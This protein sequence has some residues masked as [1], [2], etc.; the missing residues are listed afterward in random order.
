MP[1]IDL[2]TG[3]GLDIIDTQ[4]G[5]KTI[6]LLHG[7]ADTAQHMTR[8][9]DWL[10]PH[11]R[12]IAPTL[13]GY[14]ESTPKPRLF[15]VDF[16]DV[17]ARDV[18]ALMDKLD[19]QR[20]HIMGYSDG[21]EVALIAAAE[22]PDRFQSVVAWG[23]VGFFGPEV[24]PFVQR[25]FPAT[26]MDADRQRLHHIDHPDAFALRWVKAMHQMIDSGGDVSLSRA[27]QITAPLL[28]LLG[29]TDGLNPISAGQ[30]YVDRVPDGRLQTFPCGHAIHDECWPDFQRVVGDFIM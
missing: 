29:E 6:I 19:T 15:P 8:I 20:A 21:G 2:P 14:G 28:L 18:L 17:D 3:A 23:A 27:G 25:L 10:K 9:I 26:W 12:V 7:M 24:R 13:R 4:T 11:F 30:A 16:Y 5:N 1:I 22:A